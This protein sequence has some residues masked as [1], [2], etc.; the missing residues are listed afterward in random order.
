ML[1]IITAFVVLLLDQITK[2]TIKILLEP[3]ESI[4][5][6][7]G[8]FE[9]TYV[10]NKGAAFGILPGYQKL[11]IS[12]STVV[13]LMIFILFLFKQFDDKISN[14]A[15]GLIM[16][17]SIGNMIDRIISGSVID[18][19]DFKIWPVFNIADSA[20]FIG[21]FFII[22]KYIILERGG[23]KDAPGIN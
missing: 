6:I 11:F 17:G 19:F 22:W 1:F 7:K 12:V 16:G 23:N 10:G 13:V 14:I 8:I 20:V 9:I 4:S 15:F 3:N 2:Q 5:V 21:M 18:F